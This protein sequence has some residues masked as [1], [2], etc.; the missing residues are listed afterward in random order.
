MTSR[1]ICQTVG[2]RLRKG[3]QFPFWTK[4]VRTKIKPAIQ[5][6]ITYLEVRLLVERPCALIALE[7]LDDVMCFSLVFPESGQCR[8]LFVARDGVPV[9]TEYDTLVRPEVAVEGGVPVEGAR[10]SRALVSHARLRDDWFVLHHRNTFW[11]SNH[12]FAGWG[13]LESF[14]SNHLKGVNRKNLQVWNR[15]EVPNHRLEILLSV[16]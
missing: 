8:K 7:L 3:N 15:K 10:A 2:V 6:V 4:M 9:A 1:G 16:V 11:D 14:D 12:R 13:S 5:Q